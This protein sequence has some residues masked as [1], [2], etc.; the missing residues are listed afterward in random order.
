[1][2][3]LKGNVDYLKRRFRI[4]GLFVIAGLI[5]LSSEMSDGY[6]IVFSILASFGA[7][8]Y[9]NAV[10]KTELSVNNKLG[11]Y[12]S[13]EDAPFYHYIEL[14]T[15]YAGSLFFIWVAVQFI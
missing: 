9:G 11:G 5:G 4:G 8:L 2:S 15:G 6:N 13:K 14:I 10:H 1:M 12:P 3:D 7:F